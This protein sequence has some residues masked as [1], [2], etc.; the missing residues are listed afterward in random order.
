MITS[1]QVMRLL[2]AILM[3]YI[4]TLL[5]FAFAFY[6][7]LPTHDAFNNPITSFLKV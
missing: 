1:L 7:V 2:L 6:L 4:T 3:V 5:A